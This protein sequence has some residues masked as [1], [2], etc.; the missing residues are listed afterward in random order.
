MSRKQQEAVSAKILR[1][2]AIAV[3]R[4]DKSDVLLRVIDAVVRGGVSIIEI[5]MTVPNA[6]Q[7]IDRANSEFGDAITL[8]V[9][10]V[11]SSDVAMAAI[12]AGARYVVSPVMNEGVIATAKARGVVS[13][14]GTF[15]PTEAQ[16]AHEMGADFIKVFPANILGMNYFKAVLAPLPHLHLI[17]TGGVTPDNAVDWISAGAV[18]V[19]IGSALIDKNAIKEGRFEI[20][21]SR[22][23]TLSEALRNLD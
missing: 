6:I 16:R 22:A 23:A 20:L 13:I 5:T 9:G 11:V 8:G 19:G 21:T 3:L 10:S 15:T 14:P 18:A 7:Q 4:A 1:Q 17:P 2:K 12:D